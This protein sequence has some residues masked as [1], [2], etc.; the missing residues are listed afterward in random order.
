[1]ALFQ[2]FRSRPELLITATVFILLAA[3]HLHLICRIRRYPM[4]TAVGITNHVRRK[5]VES[6]MHEKRDIM[7]VQTLRNLVMAANF[8]AS[9]A[10]L[11][12]L[13]LLGAGFRPGIYTELSHAL[14]LAGAPSE[15]LW[16][17]KL[18]ILAV[19][20][21][22]AFFNF[23]LAI[24]YYNHAGLMI[25]ISESHDPDISAASVA[26]VFNHGALHYTMGMRGYY[27]SIPMVLWLFG[28]L[29]MLAGTITL[30]GLLYRLDRS[31]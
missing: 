11:V 9:T 4:T 5:W 16:M 21:F 27:L 15:G 14:N 13:G 31:A 30:I 2:I 28:P 22:S 3:Y 8:L 17:F 26:E 25:N 7:A 19:L 20:F 6:V 1:M 29:W 18:L 23:T 24:R 12:S 10:I